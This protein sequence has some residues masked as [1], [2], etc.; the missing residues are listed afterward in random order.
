M[1]RVNIIDDEARGKRNSGG[2]I[3]GGPLHER[4][5]KGLRRAAHS[6]KKIENNQPPTLHRGD[7]SVTQCPPMRSLVLP[8]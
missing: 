1:R 5:P 6:W 2:M 4:A 7:L 8:T 3:W